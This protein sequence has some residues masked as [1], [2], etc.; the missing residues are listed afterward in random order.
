VACQRLDAGVDAVEALFVRP[1][2]AIEAGVRFGQPRRQVGDVGLE[3]SHVGPEY[4]DVGLNPDDSSFQAVESGFD[5]VDPGFDTVEPGLEPI[6]SGVGAR[7]PTQ[8]EFQ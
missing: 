2:H 5:A 4:R 6:E 1:V 3:Y 8:D 7:L